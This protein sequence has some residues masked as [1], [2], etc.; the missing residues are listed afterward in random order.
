MGSKSEIL[1]RDFHH[2]M[3]HLDAGGSDLLPGERFSISPRHSSKTLAVG[4]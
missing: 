4:R 3:V 1:G 2:M